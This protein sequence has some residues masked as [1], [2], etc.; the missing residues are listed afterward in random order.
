MWPRNS[1]TVVA[2]ASSLTDTTTPDINNLTDVPRPKWA[3]A[4]TGPGPNGPRPIWVQAHMGP[5][6]TGNRPATGDRPATDRRPTG[7]RRPTV[8]PGPMGPGP[9][10]PRPNIPA[11]RRESN[12]PAR[13]RESNTPASR[14][15]IQHVIWP[16]N[17]FYHITISAQFNQH[18]IKNRIHLF[19]ITSLLSAD[20]GIYV[21]RKCL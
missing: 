16:I 15:K 8:G 19:K 20:A 12:I 17:I 21:F 10:G 4:H 13:R 7:D 11:R 3:Q 9:Y 14:Q 18:L 2:C 6:P 5:G 1:T